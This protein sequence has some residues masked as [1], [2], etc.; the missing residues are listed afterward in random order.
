MP[1]LSVAFPAYN[2]AP[3]IE[4]V[5]LRAVAVLPSIEPDYE[6]VVV[7]D[8][9]ADAT[10]ALVAEV[11]GRYPRVRLVRHEANRGYG[12]AVWTGLT[13]STG[14]QRFFTDADGQFVLEELRLLRDHLDAADMV[15]GYRRRRQDPWPRRLNGWGWSALVNMLFGYT[16]RDVD[17]AFKLMRRQVVE[18]LPVHSRGATFSAELLVK[19]RQAGYR[20]AEVG[21]THLPRRLGSASG[22]RPAVIARAFWELVALRREVRGGLPPPLR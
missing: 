1:A 13:A 11:G 5:L 12:A 9:S 8:G 10:A 22:A 6:I 16:A 20:V 14:E 18:T 4:R 15:I 7:D 3:N 2:E 21:V 17:C 19:A